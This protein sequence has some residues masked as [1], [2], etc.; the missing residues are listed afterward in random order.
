MKLPPDTQFAAG[1]RGPGWFYVVLA[2]PP[3]RAGPDLLTEARRL[4]AIV[5]KIPHEPGE[6][7]T[8]DDGE[9]ETVRVL[10][11]GGIAVWRFATREDTIAAAERIRREL[12]AV[13]H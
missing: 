10:E 6:A 1:N 5:A 2:R 3:R 11:A 8:D 4:G 9:R 12:T 13:R 7:W